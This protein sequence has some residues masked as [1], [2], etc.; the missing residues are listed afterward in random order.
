MRRW[1]RRSRNYRKVRTASVSD[2]R[3]RAASGSEPGSINRSQPIGETM[4]LVMTVI[5]YALLFATPTVAAFAQEKPQPA[6][7]PEAAAKTTSVE[8]T[9]DQILDKYVQ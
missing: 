8:P 5:I 4:K 2:S 6:K 1:R 9:V 7:A 3:V